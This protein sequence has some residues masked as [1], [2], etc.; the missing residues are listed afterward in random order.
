MVSMIVLT[1][2]TR[3]CAIVLGTDRSNVIVTSQIMVV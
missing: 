3:K 1:A 2:M